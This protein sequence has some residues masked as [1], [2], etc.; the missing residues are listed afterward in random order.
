MSK[1]ISA[2][3]F[4]A[5]TVYYSGYYL[6]HLARH[7]IRA[8]RNADHERTERTA[9]SPLAPSTPG[10]ETEEE[11]I[12]G[13]DR[14]S[15][16][17][18]TP[19]PEY[20]ESETEPTAI[21]PLA[22][23]APGEEAE[24]EQ[25]EGLDRKSPSLVTPEP[26][27]AE[28]ETE[29]TAV[30]PLAPSAP[31][32]EAEEEQIE[33]YDRKSPSLVTP[34]PEYAESE[35]E[36]TA[37]SPLAPSAPGEEAEEEQIEGL[38]RK[39]PSLVTPEPEYAE[40]ETEPTAISPLAPSAPGEEA[41][42]EQIEGSKRPS[43]VTPESE[44]AESVTEPTAI[45]PLAP[46]ASG[47]EVE[48]EQIEGLDH[49][50]PSLVTPEPE[51]AESETEPTVISP[52]APSAPGEEAEEE[53][54]EG[55][56]RK[57]PSLVTPEP[58][59]AESE[60]EPT[61]I[62]PLAPSAP[63]EEA[64]EEHIEGSKRPSLVTPESEYAESETEPTA[65]SPLAPS[66]PGEE[67]EEEQIEGYDLK[68][69][70]LV[71]PEPEYAESDIKAEQ[72]AVLPEAQ[73]D[74][75]E[76]KRKNEEDI[77]RIEEEMTLP[78]HR[79]DQQNQVGERVAATPLTK[80][81]LSCFLEK[82]KEQMDADLQKAQAKWKAREMNQKEEMKI[83]REKLNP[84]PQALQKQVQVLTSHLAASEDFQQMSGNEEPQRWRK[85]QIY[86]GSVTKPA[87]SA[88]LPKGAFAPRPEKRRRGSLLISRV[89]RAA[90]QQQES[91]DD[92]LKLLRKMV[93]MENPTTK[94]TELGNIGRGTFGDVCRALNN[95][96]GGEV[97]IKKINLQGLRKKELKVN[98]LRIM[99]MN[100]NPNL[101]NYLDS[102]L[103]GEHL[104]LVMEYMDGGTLRDVIS[105]CYLSEDET[106]AI[107]R[108]CLRGLDFLHSNHVIHL[109]VKSRNI[110]LG[111]DGSVK[112]ADF[113]LFAELTPEQNRQSSMACTSGWMAPEVVTGQPYGPKVDIWSF[114]IVGIEMVEREVP[115]WNE[116]PGTAELL[117]ARGGGPQLRQP[118]RFSPCL[119][120]FLS[121]CLQPDVMCRWSA[122]D[123]LQH[124]F[125]TSAKPVSTL[126]ALFN[127]AKKKKKKQEETRM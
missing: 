26:E 38:D 69:P 6:S 27:Y 76:V 54:I 126:A 122:K 58:E 45:S 30:S 2:A 78:Q 9:F 14:K 42:E 80:L 105:K 36:P 127:L 46:S 112:L 48:E 49:K 5:Y 32:E 90:A 125:V 75:M 17:L 13:Y 37:I 120:D 74:T 25:I 118:N 102:Y 41:E 73:S 15:P 92:S 99:K 83:I 43:L 50:S 11:Q 89:D 86:K 84:L 88:S 101:I 104:C 121:C 70:S 60:T 24:E 59:Y 55:Y 20:A 108:E 23:S 3:V 63:G 98:E 22:P 111:T 93:T 82:M 16:S 40:S 52:L 57:S 106:A 116:T 72:Q 119:C 28:P 21:S 115:Y 10:E 71:T 79:G 87:A 67:A 62:S 103:L 96:T 8:L 94:Y 81:P 65:I 47:E 97:A 34:E 100:R 31:G 95:A 51:Y 113:G 33:G 39:S 64:E 124:P 123:L 1:E 7:L 12:E 91:E 19:E 66:A 35:T 117:T 18:V 110:L 56:D 109:D 77:T 4:A 107:S 68:S 114:G 44:Y 29:P 61:A 85:A 53:Q